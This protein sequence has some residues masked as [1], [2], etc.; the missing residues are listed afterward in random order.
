MAFRVEFGCDL[1]SRLVDAQHAGVEVE[2]FRRERDQLAQPHARRHAEPHEDLGRLVR[3]GVINALELR[4]RCHD[5][6]LA[7]YSFE[8]DPA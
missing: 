2:V 1:N 7:W 6:R 8:P 3:Q 4:A 5:Y